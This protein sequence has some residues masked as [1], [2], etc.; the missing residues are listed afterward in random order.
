MSN[1][2]RAIVGA[3]QASLRVRFALP[4]LF[5]LMV[6]VHSSGAQRQFAQAKYVPVNVISTET[7]NE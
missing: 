7:G 1:V 4:V 3:N 6:S 2:K 5:E